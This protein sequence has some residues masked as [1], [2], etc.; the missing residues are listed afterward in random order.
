MLFINNAIKLKLN[1]IAKI[2]KKIH[3]VGIM[4]IHLE[5]N[6]FLTNYLHASLRKPN[7]LNR[8]PTRKERTHLKWHSKRNT[9]FHLKFSGAIWKSPLHGKENNEKCFYAQT[10]VNR[11]ISQKQTHN[12]NV[13]GIRKA[14]QQLENYFVVRI[15]MWSDSEESDWNKCVWTVINWHGDEDK[16]ALLLHNTSLAI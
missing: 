12:F 11:K 10:T 6:V 9:S 13:T 3:S 8:S 2:F 16:I 5:S 14:C 15:K 7:N 4:W 1:K